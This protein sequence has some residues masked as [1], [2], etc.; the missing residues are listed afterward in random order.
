MLYTNKT[1]EFTTNKRGEKVLELNSLYGQFISIAVD[2][3]INPNIKSVERKFHKYLTI[4]E[5]CEGRF[6]LE[7]K[8][9]DEIYLV[10]DT[11]EYKNFNSDTFIQFPEGHNYFKLLKNIKMTD[12]AGKRKWNIVILKWIKPKSTTVDGK[13][14]Y[15]ED[16]I[17]KY[18]DTSGTVKYIVIDNKGRLH[19]TNEYKMK[20]TRGEEE[21]KMVSLI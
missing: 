20:L 18:K 5:I 1:L 2:R 12:R 21:T 16:S 3:N 13:I 17:I 8:K 11:L 15:E 19:H 6:R 9:D 4:K 14:K 10:I 7:N